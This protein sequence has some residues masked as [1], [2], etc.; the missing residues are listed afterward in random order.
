MKHGAVAPMMVVVPGVID[1]PPAPPAPST[2]WFEASSPIYEF[3]ATVPDVR[4]DIVSV[5]PENVKLPENVGLPVTVPPSAGDVSVLLVSVCVPVRFT[6][7]SD[8][9]GIRMVPAIAPAAGCKVSVPDVT[10]PRVID[11]SVADAPRVRCPRT[12]EALASG[13]QFCEPSV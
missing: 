8:P 2:R 6:N 10:L 11:P 4:P 13:R 5:E 7:V 1:A 3:A 9:D 12:T